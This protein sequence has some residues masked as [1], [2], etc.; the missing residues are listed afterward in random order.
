MGFTTLTFGLTI[1]V[2]TDG[3]TNYGQ[4]LLTDTWQKLSAHDHT[5]A[6]KGTQITSAAIAANA[7]SD[8]Q[9]RLSNN[10]Y[11]RG[12][13]AANS[14]DINVLKVDAADKILFDATAVAATTRASLGL[15]IGTH[16]QA[17]NA[18]LSAIAGLAVTDSNFIVGNG[19]T[20]VAETGATVRASLGLTIGTHVA[21]AGSNSDITALNRCTVL[22]A[23]N[24]ANIYLQTSDGY[25]WSILSG[26]LY[27]NSNTYNIGTLFHPIGNLYFHGSFVNCGTSQ[28]WDFSAGVSNWSYPTNFVSSFN[29]DASLSDFPSVVRA[30]GN[31]INSIMYKLDVLGVIN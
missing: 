4:T 25:V 14:A 24:S 17:Y 26:D 12:R 22:G 6:G 29:C 19:S 2:P 10:T 15:T 8:T 27:P 20:W 3:T 11:L 1:K 16:V 28:T 13:N 30:V 7:I 9:F 21:A 23:S 18:N 31:A 5:G